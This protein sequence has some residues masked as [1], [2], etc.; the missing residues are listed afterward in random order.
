MPRCRRCTCRPP[1]SQAD[2]DELQT[3]NRLI[4]AREAGRATNRK[5][6]QINL[7]SSIGHEN[8]SVGYAMPAP[9]LR[10][11]ISTYSLTV[12]AGGSQPVF[13][14]VYPE[15]AN[16]RLTADGDMAACTGPGELLRCNPAAG[17][18]PTSHSTHF[19]LAPGRYWTIGLLPLGWARMLEVDACDFA[20]R[21]TFLDQ[22]PEF[23]RFT[24][25]VDDIACDDADMAAARID[26]RLTSLLMQPP[27]DE[28][29][30]TRTHTALIDPEVTT[31]SDLAARVGTKIHTLERLCRSVFGFPPKL[32]L[33][34]QRFLRSLSQFMLDPSLAWINTMDTQ[35]VDQAHFIRDFRRFMDTTPSAYAARP[36]PVLWA[37]ARARAAVSGKVMQVLQAPQEA[38]TRG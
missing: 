27:R 9:E 36:H 35:Y 16:I 3:L 14:E 31:V 38:P 22:S 32:L 11:Y 37:A 30:I 21:W 1:G 17:I 24:S 29:A 19:S 4:L 5:G 6:L 33:R 34:R 28:H 12:V 18:G 23:A 26:Q 10:P 25:L 13:D 8:V 7:H 2:L 15:W 20:D